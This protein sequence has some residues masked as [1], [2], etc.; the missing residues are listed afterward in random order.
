M[1]SAPEDFE[2][3][4]KLLRLLRHEQPPPGY[5]DLF[6]DRVIRSLGREGRASSVES[7][8]AGVPWLQKLRD[9]WETNP[10][11]TGAC[12]LALCGLFAAGLVLS[13]SDNQAPF[14]FVVN[15]N[16]AYD[17]ASALQAS[18]TVKQPGLEASFPSTAP[19]FGTNIPG[20]SM[21]GGVSLNVQPVSF[22]PARQ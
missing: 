8:W 6:S 21:F 14:G 10:L 3:L 22:S 15:P 1:S 19:V 16:G 17:E 5:F 9:L 11:A 20:N 18:I 12:G 2:G 13:Q 4:R 7:A